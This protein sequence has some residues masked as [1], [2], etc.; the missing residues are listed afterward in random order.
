MLS[1]P[2]NRTLLKLKLTIELLSKNHN[3]TQ[4]NCGVD[5]LNFFLQRIARQHIEKG[6]SKTF[7]LVDIDKPTEIIAYMTLVVCEVFSDE[8]PHNWKKKYPSRIPAAK[9]ARLAVSTGK[10]GNK[11][12]QALLMD[13]IQKTLNASNNIGI[14]GLFVDAKDETAKAYYNQFGFL[15]MPDQLDNLFLPLASLTKLISH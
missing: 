9:L 12:G 8:I 10:Q 5:D 4:F 7:V 14:A 6:L 3:R 11:H 13:A 15:S 1:R 2:T